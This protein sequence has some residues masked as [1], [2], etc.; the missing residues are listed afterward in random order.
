ML[1]E[2]SLGIPNCLECGKEPEAVWSNDIIC[3]E[4]IVHIGFSPCEHIVGITGE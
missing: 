3:T 2:K 1:V 4:H